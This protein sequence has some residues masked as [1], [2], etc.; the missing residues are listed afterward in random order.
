[1]ESAVHG[2]P[3]NAVKNGKFAWDLTI[4]GWIFWDF[5]G[6][7]GKF[8]AH[9]WIQDDFLGF[10]MSLSPMLRRSD[11]WYHTNLLESTENGLVPSP[12]Y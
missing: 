6:F 10:G 8:M 12:Y 11:I 3:Q 2:E 1:M 5:M 4:L 7:Y 9:L